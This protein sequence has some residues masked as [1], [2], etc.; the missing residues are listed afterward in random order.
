MRLS[1]LAISLC[2]ASVTAIAA[3]V[4][5]GPTYEIVE[6]DTLEEI[7]TRL[8]QQDW[9]KVLRK[10][11]A[12]YAAFKAAPLPPASRTDVRIFDPTYTLPYD[13]RDGEGQ[14]LAAKGTQVNVYDRLKLPGRYIVIDGSDKHLRWLEDV[15]RPT[16]NDRVLIA[17]G[18]VYSTRQRAKYNFWLLDER[19]I[20][21]FGLK[22]V[23]SIVEQSGRL[24][25][26][27]EFA[28]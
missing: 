11:P 27:Q 5:I 25:K 22:A 16:D 6:P 28:L 10:E 12:Q 21:R 17:G 7:R 13:L 18:N 8:S 3:D 2:L 4:V 14:L 19:G 26:V 20:E 15:A 9:E 1:A 23:P 24:L